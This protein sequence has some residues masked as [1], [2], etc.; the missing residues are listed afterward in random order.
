MNIKNKLK[1]HPALKKYLHRFI[2]HPVKTRPNWWIRIFSFIYIKKGKKSVIYRS[3]R[4]DIVP[5]NIFKIGDFS[6]VED[7]SC[8]NNAVGN[9]QIGDNT[10]I[11]LSNTII[12]PVAIGNNTNIAQNVVISGLNHNFLDIEKTI[13]EQGISVKEIAIGDDV[14]IGANSVILAGVSIGRHSIIAAGSVV[15]RSIPSY[16]VCTGIPAK[17]IKKYDFDSNQWIKVK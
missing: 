8:I 11:G 5:F 7:F 17:V 4:K 10:R 13:S 12:G 3:V 1:E 6:V 9:I 14:W 16:C 2:M 15:S